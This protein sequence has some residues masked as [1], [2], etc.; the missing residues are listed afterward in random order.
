MAFLLQKTVNVT[1]FLLLCDYLP[2]PNLFHPCFAVSPVFEYLNPCFLL[3]CC[4][5]VCFVLFKSLRKEK[6][7]QLKKSVQPLCRLAQHSS[8]DYSSWITFIPPLNLIFLQ[9]R[10]TKQFVCLSLFFLKYKMYTVL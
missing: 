4:Q 3:L 7:T 1:I 2:H 5:L 8:W 6:F 10:G 9:T